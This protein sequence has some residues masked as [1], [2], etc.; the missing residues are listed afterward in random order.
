M[1]VIPDLFGSYQ[2]GREDAIQANWQ[3]LA[4][5]EKIQQART[6][7]DRANLQLLAEQ[8]DYGANRS[9]VQNTADASSMATEQLF[10]L[11]PGKIA[12]ADQFSDLAG[13]QYGVTKSAIADGTIPAIY[14]NSIGTNLNTSQTNFNT[15]G[16]NSLQSGI[17]LGAVRNNIPALT[18]S[19][20]DIVAGN[21]AA[22]SYNAK[23]LLH[24]A[25]QDQGLRDSNA[26][27]ALSS[28]A[29]AKTGTDAAIPKQAQ[30]VQSGQTATI[31]GNIASA[32]NS[33]AAAETA[34]LTAA[35]Q[36]MAAV[37]A[38][39]QQQL[40][41][42][43]IFNNPAASDGDR[44]AAI[45]NYNALAA[46][47]ESIKKLTGYDDGQPYKLATFHGSQAQQVPAVATVNNPMPQPAAQPA[48]TTP[49]VTTPA[50]A[51]VAQPVAN[52]NMVQYMPLF[53]GGV[54]YGAYASAIPQT[55]TTADIFNMATG[56]PVAQTPNTGTI[57][58]NT[59]T[60]NK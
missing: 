54:D 50:Q 26:V 16:V 32:S 17:N 49:A 58:L 39:R 31:F 14:A 36:P 11:Q 27:V 15:S 29:L 57:L 42:A 55:A 18:Q 52:G 43:Q 34:K 53:S 60:Q 37:Q 12:Q 33:A 8:Q 4:N 44:Q 51:V 20:N 6:A 28:N 35:Q 22:T 9:V 40:N 41:Y 5:Y 47:I 21:A 1:L 13:V 23:N 56:K 48:V 46:D 10:H 2:K 59:W 25:E 19:A 7:N 30:V 3:D 38:L 45:A 24:N